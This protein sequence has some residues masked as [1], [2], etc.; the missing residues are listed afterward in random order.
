VKA[1][2]ITSI[3]NK[4]EHLERE[5]NEIKKRIYRLEEEHKMKLEH[6][7]KTMGDSFEGHEIWFEWKSLI[8]L[9]KSMEEELRELKKMFKEIVKEDVAT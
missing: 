2:I 5:L 8:E 7:E 1:A 4:I 9:K 6:F 3:E